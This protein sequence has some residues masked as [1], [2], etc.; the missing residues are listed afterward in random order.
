[1]ETIAK[2]VEA[3][4][5]GQLAAVVLQT[6]DSQVGQ[7]EVPKLSNR[8]PM[9]DMY[10]KAV[11]LKLEG[12]KKGFP[13]CMAF[14]YWNFQEAAKLVGC[15]NP[16]PRTAGVKECNEKATQP[17]KVSKK[18]ALLHP[19]LVLPGMQFILDFGAKGG[20]TGIVTGVEKIG[21]DWSYHTIEGNTNDDG[22][23]DGYEVARRVRK[24]SNANLVCFINWD[25]P[26]FKPL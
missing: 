8:G 26:V 11:G 2:L 25:F 7:Q 1:M 9:V 23:R 22:E 13:W 18:A 5:I 20:H 14:V 4:K 3:G 15:A 6:A 17:R 12:K 19:E 16:V 10:Q 21:N 24:F